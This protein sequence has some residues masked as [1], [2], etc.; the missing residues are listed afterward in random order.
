MGKLSSHTDLDTFTLRFQDHCGDLEV[1]KKRS[2]EVFTPVI[3]IEGAVVMDVGGAL[4]SWSDGE[5]P[6]FMQAVY[7]H[8]RL[9]TEA[10]LS[11]G[12]LLS[13]K[14]RVHLP[15]LRDRSTGDELMTRQ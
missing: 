5:F 11:L 3:P 9:E 2:P 1:E 7:D 6:T 8:A 15:L 14:H 13:T 12:Y 4:M 10:E